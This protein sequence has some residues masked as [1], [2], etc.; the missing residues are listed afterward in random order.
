MAEP[1]QRPEA[2]RDREHRVRTEA[3]EAEELR[4]LLLSVAYRMVG[5]FAEAEDIVQDALV[6]FHQATRSGTEIRS[7][8][9]Y[10]TAVTTRRAIDHLRSARV[11]RDSYV[12]TWLPEPLVDELAPDL[13]EQA[14][15]SDSLSTAFLVLLEAM[16]PVERAVFLLREVFGYGYDEIAGVVGK[17]EDNCRQIAVRARRR[18]EAGQ[19]RFEASRQERDRLAERFLAASH[20]GDLAGL[21]SLLAAD[22]AFYGDGGA[23]G[24]GLAEPVFGRDRVARVVLALVRR[25]DRAGVRMQAVHVGGQPGLLMLDHDDQV[26]A[27]WSLQVAEGAVQTIHGV[28]NPEKLGHLGPTSPLAWR[29]RQ[30]VDA[31]SE[32]RP[33]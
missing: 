14:E 16:S 15:L 31:R 4:P 9:A 29:A 19:A 26:V 5:S 30:P 7:V 6:R 18:I 8:R 22:A 24:N 10:L 13:A 27:V 12:G 1:R 20:E 32:R 2:D 17:T 23:R 33:T 11:R 3:A 28:V 21:V 25:I